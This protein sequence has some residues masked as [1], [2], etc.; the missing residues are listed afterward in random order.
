[1]GLLLTVLLGVSS[2]LES[3]CMGVAKGDYKLLFGCTRNWD[4]V[5]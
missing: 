2:E 5:N 1:M 4:E 3:S